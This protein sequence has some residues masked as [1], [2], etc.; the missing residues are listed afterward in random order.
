MTDEQIRDFRIE[1]LDDAFARGTDAPYAC[2]RALKPA[3]GK[4]QKILRNRARSQV[5]DMMATWHA[6]GRSGIAAAL[7]VLG[8]S[9]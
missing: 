2:L 5:M 7:L 1:L 8:R 9:S 4:A 6:S 3:R